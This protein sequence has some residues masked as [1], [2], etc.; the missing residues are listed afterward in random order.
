LDR[1]KI[2][3]ERL[4]MIARWHSQI[5]KQIGNFKLSELAPSDFRNAIEFVEISADRQRFSIVAL[6]APANPVQ[7]VD[8]CIRYQCA[9]LLFM[10][11]VFARKT[12]GTANGPNKTPKKIQK[13]VLS[14]RCLAV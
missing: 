14:P 13:G 9:P 10:C 5:I 6:A 8:T 7:G 12:K 11:F 3:F 4:K 2:T 1:P